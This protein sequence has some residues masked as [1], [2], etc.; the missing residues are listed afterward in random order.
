MLGHFTTVVWYTANDVV[1]RDPGMVPGTAS[2][3]ANDEM[4]EMRSYMNE[5][6]KLLY[7]GQYAGF[8][9]AGGYAFDPVANAPCGTGDETVD[10]RCQ[11]LSDDFLQYYLGAYIYNDGGGQDPETGEPFAVAGTGAPFDGIDWTLNGPD[12]AD[13]QA[14]TASFV[15]TSSLLPEDEYP[16]FEATCRRTGRPASPA[17]SSRTTATSTCTPIVPT[18]ATSG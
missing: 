13:N 1:T 15:N 17:P 8:Q 10:A 2:R 18:S 3:L 12:S 5:G 7:N 9:Y 4:L 14:H 16:Q 6:G 11:A